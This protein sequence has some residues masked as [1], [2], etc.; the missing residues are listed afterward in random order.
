MQSDNYK[1][2][3]ITGNDKLNSTFITTRAKALMKDW[4]FNHLAENYSLSADWNNQWLTGGTLEEVV[5]EAHLSQD[6]ILSG[7]EKFVNSKEERMKT[8]QEELGGF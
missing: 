3:V 6:W 2:K 1:N 5:D 4:T 8:F 7:I